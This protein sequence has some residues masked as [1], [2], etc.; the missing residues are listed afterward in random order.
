MPDNR[1][2]PELSVKD[3]DNSLHFY[4]DIVEFKVLFER[5]EDRFAYMSFY[6]SE[7][8]IEEVSGREDEST[9]IIQPLDY[10]RGRGLN[11]SIDC[12][13]ADSLVER[14]NAAEIPLR[15]PIEEHWYRGD[16]ILYGQRNFLVQ[17]PDGYLLR[18]AEKP[19]T[20]P[21]RK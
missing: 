17:D 1:L 4:R 15:K 7:L 11:I 16:D 6:G 13:N 3:I 2:V 14:L 9:W 18:F 8:M 20:K 19:G 21:V 10:P 5:R 12:P